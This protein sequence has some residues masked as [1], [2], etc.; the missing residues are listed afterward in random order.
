MPSSPLS[1]DS[2]SS[3]ERIDQDIISYPSTFSHAG[4]VSKMMYTDAQ[5]ASEG[6]VSSEASTELSEPVVS[7]MPTGFMAGSL[8]Q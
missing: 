1:R 3:D 5:G 6:E 8:K 4:E 7:T 2:T